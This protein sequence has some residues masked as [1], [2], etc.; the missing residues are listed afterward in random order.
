M[1][2]RDSIKDIDENLETEVSQTVHEEQVLFI[3][4]PLFTIPFEISLQ[5]FCVRNLPIHADKRNWRILSSYVFTK[6]MEFS[7]TSD[8][9]SCQNCVEVFS[10]R[11]KMYFLSYSSW[12][13]TV[14]EKLQKIASTP[15][16]SCWH[17]STIVL[18]QESHILSTSIHSHDTPSSLQKNLKH[19]RAILKNCS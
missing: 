18:V 3:A 10:W 1:C 7:K 9:S 12:L 5:E 14:M 8:S 19:L 13:R 11:D 2:I 15:V 4:T 16:V 6:F 17:K